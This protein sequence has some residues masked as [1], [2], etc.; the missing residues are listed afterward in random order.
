MNT[1][2][3]LPN[4]DDLDSLMITV[5][6]NIAQDI[7]PL[8]DILKNLSITPSDFAKWK[9][10]P[11]FH[12]YIREEKAA[13]ADAHNAAVR[14]K[15]KAGVVLERFME[16]IDSDL[17]KDVI[18]LNQRIEGAKLLA[19]ITG[20]GEPKNA[21]V[22]GGGGFQLHINIGS[23]EGQNVTINASK[24]IDHTQEDEGPDIFPM[25]DDA[26]DLLASPDTLGDL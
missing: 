10:N 16:K 8:E 26:Y 12:A 15:L 17:F 18:P 23:G 21:A 2:L 25:E 1:A 9:D 3:S 4:V 6:R 13:W 19:K 24:V 7:Y 20:L 22:A 11:R 14:T 5:A